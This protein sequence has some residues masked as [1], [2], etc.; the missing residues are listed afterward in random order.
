MRRK[1]PKA[2]AVLR[3]TDGTAAVMG[4]VL[5][6]ALDIKE[7]GDTGRWARRHCADLRR[8]KRDY[9]DLQDP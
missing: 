2:I 3:N 1:L 8:E 6:W 7:G 4:E 9:T 5:R